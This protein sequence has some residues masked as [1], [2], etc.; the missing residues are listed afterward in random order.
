MG[1]FS[2]KNAR[3]AAQ[4]TGHILGQGQNQAFNL[5]DQE[6]NRGLGYLNQNYGIYN[7][8]YNSAVNA[9]NSGFNAAQPYYQNAQA[10]FN[11]YQAVGNQATSAYQDAMGF[12]GAEGSARANAAFRTAP[13]YQ[14]ALDQGLGAVERSAAARG[15]GT[16]GNTMVDLTK[17]ATGFADQTY[18]TYMG[19]LS[20]GMQQGFAAAQAKSAIDQTQAGNAINQGNVLGNM[21]MSHAGNLAGVNSS[22]A[23]Y[24][25]NTAL[26]KANML[27]DVANKNAIATQEAYN[28]KDKANANRFSAWMGGAKLL[29]GFFG[30]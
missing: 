6:Q 3:L 12:N 13:G 20:N 27:M 2:A 8:G 9:I 16:S 4:A 21:A 23:G 24:G 10:H 19:N 5:L 7:N 25:Q 1:I 30:L 11:P 15:M 17:Y 28:A 18:N 22:I 26:T 14:F 29:G